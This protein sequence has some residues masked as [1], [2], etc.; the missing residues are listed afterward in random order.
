[1]SEQ[2]AETEEKPKHPMVEVRVSL[3]KPFYD[4][5]TEYLQF[6]GS[7]QTIEDV[8][9]DMIYFELESIYRKLDEFASK[10]VNH[11]DKEGWFDRFSHLAVVSFPAP[12]EE[13]EQD[14]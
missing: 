5:L 12:D 6:F 11:V 1:M 10:E 8:C 2:K 9:R 13:E 4:F 7:T 14:E 3:Y